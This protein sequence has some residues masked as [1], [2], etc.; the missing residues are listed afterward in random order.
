MFSKGCLFK[1]LDLEPAG[2]ADENTWA[3]PYCHLVFKRPP[4]DMTN[5]GKHQD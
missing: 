4:Q 2:V 5:Y 1:H 3:C